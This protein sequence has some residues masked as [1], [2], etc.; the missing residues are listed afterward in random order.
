[1]LDITTSEQVTRLLS[2]RAEQL[3]E[4]GHHDE[5]VVA[6]GS[7]LLVLG[8]ISRPTKDV[9]V[10][11][12]L[13]AGVAR[14]ADPF[15]P[16]LIAARDRVSRDF[17]LPEKWL[18]PGPAALMDHGLPGGF[19]DRVE[20]RS[21]GRGLTIHFASRLDQ[22]HFKLYALVDQGVGKHEQDLRALEPT[23]DELIQAAR[24]TWSHDPSVGFRQMPEEALRY[25][26]VEY[27]DLGP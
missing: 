10:V 9:D 19:F 3:A 21:F 11:A 16:E 1:M 22:I 27:A 4:A 12:C 20:P 23:A 2:A 25:L 13:D 15:P 26:G 6:G 14:K 7:A 8:I 17:G 18:N 24:W 5:L